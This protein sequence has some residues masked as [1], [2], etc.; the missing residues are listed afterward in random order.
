ME[1]RN[2]VICDREEGFVSAF[3]HYLLKREEMAFQVQTCSDPAYVIKVQEKEKI[4]YLF[5]SAVYSKEEREGIEAG[6]I[7]VLTGDG[8]TTLRENETAVYKYQSGEDILAHLI[9]KCSIEGKAEGTF[10]KTIRKKQVRIIG[11]YSPVHRVG[12]TSYALRLGE[13]LSEEA[14]V[15]YLNMESYGGIEGH[16]TEVS[17]G[18]SDVLYYARQEK[19]NLGMILTTIVGH[20][21]KLDYVAPVQV[22]EDLKSVQGRE[23]TLLIQKI[24]EQSIYEILILDM[25]EGVRE[26]YDV[27]RI[28]GEIHMMTAP[29]MAAES[30]VRQFEE[31]LR[32]LGYEDIRSKVIYR[33]SNYD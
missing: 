24:M 3:A 25:D 5:I 32:L 16:F 15:L 8:E 23:W 31:E 2:L 9:K 19:S 13:R 22:S 26:I 4:D 30:K 1:S 28:C 14:N 7:F 12:K 11:V 27:L 21:G 17:Q 6:K 29:D 10:F 33:E 18:L 20:R